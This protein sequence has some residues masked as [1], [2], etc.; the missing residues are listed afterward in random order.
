MEDTK[1]SY[2]MSQS[3]QAVQANCSRWWYC[4]HSTI[5]SPFQR[6]IGCETSCGERFMLLR[7][8]R[9]LIV[10]KHFFCSFWLNLTN[11]KSNS[12]IK[13]FRVKLTFLPLI[14]NQTFNNVLST[15]KTIHVIL[16]SRGVRLWETLEQTNQLVSF[17]NVSTDIKEVQSPRS[18]FIE[19]R[20][21][22]GFTVF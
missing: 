7:S 11:Y 17:L 16:F 20:S 6:A 4:I 22:L 18:G 3:I 14:L 10:N 2:I 15:L 5:F 12:E 21:H 1:S 13:L 9:I 8:H 19:Q